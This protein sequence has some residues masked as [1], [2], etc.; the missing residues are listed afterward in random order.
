MDQVL[1]VLGGNEGDT[2]DVMAKALRLL[3]KDL[4]VLEAVSGFY[5]SEPWGFESAQNFINL[6]ALYSVSVSP[7]QG[8]KICLEV[9]KQLGRLRDFCVEGYQSRPIDIDIVLWGGQIINSKNLTV[10]HP[11][12]SERRFVL[13]PCAEIAGDWVHPVLGGTIKSLLEKC[14]DLSFV[15]LLSKQK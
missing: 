13:M 1:I 5:E 10:P 9:E 7:Q 6:S 8:L 12:M 14:E 11:L 2:V 15:N 4:G 3:S